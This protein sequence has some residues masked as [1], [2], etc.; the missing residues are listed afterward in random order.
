MNFV[1]FCPD[2]EE[3]TMIMGRV[4]H[5]LA[6]QKIWTPISVGQTIRW[7]RRWRITLKP[8]EKLKR[9]G[10]KNTSA[11]AV[12]KEQLYVRHMKVEEKRWMKSNT[13]VPALILPDNKLWSGLPVICTESG[14]VVLAPHFE[15]ND[16]SYGVDCDVTFDPLLP[17]LDTDYAVG[18]TTRNL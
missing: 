8:L 17:L 18:M 9:R 15:I 5:M 1:L 6:Q 13:S 14:F 16:H 4:S 10:S 11:G 2:M 7:D 12:R 3:D